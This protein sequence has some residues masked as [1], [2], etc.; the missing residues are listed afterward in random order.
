MCGICGIVH[1]TGQPVE[2][3]EVQGM[4]DRLRHRGPD[5]QGLFLDGNT[6]LGHVR[7]S[8]LDLT[9]NGR[10]PMFSPDG[11]HCLIYN[12]EVYNAPELREELKHRHDFRTRT[13]TEVVLQTFLAWGPDC[14]PKLD[15]MFAFAL[16]D[17]Q[18]RDLFVARDRFGIKPFFYF[19]DDR[20]FV[21]A[22]E[23]RALLPFLR[24]R[25]PN[26]QAVYEYLAFNRT[27][28]G[29][30][31][32]FQGVRRLPHGCCGMVRDGRLA[33][34]KWYRLEDS[35][36]APFREP[37]EFY[38]AFAGSV[39]RQLRS[40]VPVGVCLSGGLDSSSIVSVILKEENRRDLSTFSAVYEK[41][42]AAD[43]SGF[44]QEYGKDLENMFFTNPDADGLL[45]D[46]DRFVACHAE[47]VATLGPYAQFKVME[48]AGRHVKV[49]LDGQGADEMLAGYH[50]FFGSYFKELFTN[51]RWVRLGR[52]MAA[53]F[54]KHRSLYALRYFALY[55]APR[56]TKDALSRFHHSHITRDFY[57]SGK[58][59]SRIGADLYAPRTL[60]ESLRQH[61]EHKLEHL[62][63]WEDHNSMAH[64]VE[65]RVPFLDHSLV[66]RTLALPAGWKIHQATTKYFLR[67]AMKDIL[68]ERIRTRADKIGFATPWARWFRAPAFRDRILDVLHSRTFRERGYLEPERC[69]RDYRHHLE[70]KT[71]IAKEIWKWVNLELWFAA[72]IDGQDTPQ[73]PTGPAGP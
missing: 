52:E 54:R 6:G 37:R 49:T 22:S 30:D 16:Y 10:Q 63:K 66:E 45:A 42:D 65:S 24:E 20:L 61:F 26:P 12:G 28:Q 15:G 50:Y 68:P 21:F 4:M 53:Y 36:Q 17:R 38:E 56:S 70:G 64:S 67:E 33:Q 7:L 51:F 69:L 55:L 2:A 3:I 5:G 41:G 11:R 23:E 60:N 32:F 43:E 8:I 31:S 72:F 9:P 58:N 18:T 34:R 71:D 73:C 1:T 29:N 44:I 59:I 25:K 46:L 13:D 14:L 62:L 57:Q 27:G 40:D 39:R 48:L 47:P 19:Q 35:R